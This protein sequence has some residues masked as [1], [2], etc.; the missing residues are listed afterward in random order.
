M[1][2]IHVWSNFQAVNNYQ[3]SKRSSKYAFIIETR[4]PQ[5]HASLQFK[6]VTTEE[7][8]KW[9]TAIDE[10]L[11][12][13]RKMW[14]S[15]PAIKIASDYTLCKLPKIKQSK[16]QIETPIVPVSVLDKWLEQL[17]F[18]DTPEQ[19]TIRNYRRNS[20]CSGTS[21]SRRNC[22][23]GSFQAGSNENIE[24]RNSFKKKRMQKIVAHY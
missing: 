17:D 18:L 7:K 16:C 2:E 24:C 22:R 4:D 21:S 23:R 1:P 15:Q 8:D 10:Q 12:L 6:C 3:N 19:P 5:I 9:I 14:S 20:N 13:T 11:K